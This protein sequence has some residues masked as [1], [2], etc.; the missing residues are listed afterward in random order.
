VILFCKASGIN[1][2]QDT[3]S[4]IDFSQAEIII[5]LLLQA[6]RVAF[7]GVGTSSVIAT[8]AQYRFAQLGI[9]TSAFWMPL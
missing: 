4:M 2:L 7:F 3:L 8:D 9:A 6:T 1:T 5:R